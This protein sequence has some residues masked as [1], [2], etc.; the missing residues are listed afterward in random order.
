LHLP[1]HSCLPLH[2]ALR[3]P[4]HLRKTV[5]RTA[6]H[7]NQRDTLNSKHIESRSRKN[8]KFFFLQVCIINV[9][10]FFSM[11]ETEAAVALWNRIAR[12]LGCCVLPLRTPMCL[13]R[14]TPINQQSD[15]LSLFQRKEIAYAPFM[16]VKGV[17]LVRCMSSAFYLIKH[18]GV[19]NDLHPSA[20]VPKRNSRLSPNPN[21]THP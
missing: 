6:C 16:G 1:L 17:G 18:I 21:S 19:R 9:F 8:P 13:I 2:L 20:V 7:M 3:L 10:Y 5:A 11:V 12:S 14:S 15:G 4:S